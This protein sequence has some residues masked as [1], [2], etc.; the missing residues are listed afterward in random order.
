MRS[1]ISLMA[2][3][4]PSSALAASLR[5]M[6]RRTL[7][8]SPSTLVRESSLS[9]AS[10]TGLVVF[11][12]SGGASLML[13][14]PPLDGTWIELVRRTA[15]PR[16]IGRKA[17]VLLPM[18]PD[19]GRGAAR[20]EGALYL[21]QDRL[22]PRSARERGAHPHRAL[23]CGTGPITRKHAEIRDRRNQRAVIILQNAKRK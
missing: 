5:A 7:F 2:P 6:S 17:D 21:C 19:H 23:R 4:S 8:P 9:S 10:R 11:P 20:R 16:D 13:M 1:K 3:R 15:P 12:L 22:F 18:P 14:A